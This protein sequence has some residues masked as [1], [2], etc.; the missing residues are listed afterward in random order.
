LC[1][2]FSTPSKMFHSIGNGPICLP[3]DGNGK[4]IGTVPILCNSYF[5]NLHMVKTSSGT[6]VRQGLIC[7]TVDCHWSRFWMIFASSI[8]AKLFSFKRILSSIFSSGFGNSFSAFLRNRMTK[9]R[10]AHFF[11][12]FGGMFLSAESSSTASSS[13]SNVVPGRIINGIKQL[14]EKNFSTI[15]FGKIKCNVDI[16]TLK[17]GSTVFFNGSKE[18]MARSKIVFPTSSVSSLSNIL[19]AVYQAFG[20][21]YES[22]RRKSM[23]HFFIYH[24]NHYH[25]VM[26][27][28]ARI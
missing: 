26:N 25:I 12:R 27:M 14:D 18:M 16:G 15:Q 17:I 1:Y 24:R 19:F 20:D 3:V 22:V 9:L 11:N 28:V 5:S 10:F 4:R 2:P 8:S 21:V 6:S 13:L 23:F 7:N